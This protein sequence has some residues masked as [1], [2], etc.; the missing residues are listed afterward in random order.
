MTQLRP[1]SLCN[2]VYKIISKV[3]ANR[4]KVLLPK[5]ISPFKSAFVP[6]RAIS[7]NTILTSEIANFLC[8]RPMGKK[9]FFTLKL[10]MCKAYDKIKWSYLECVLLKLGFNT[11]WVNL[12][13][14]CVYSVLYTFIVN[15]SPRGYALPSRGLR[16]GDPISP[17][18]FL[19][20]AKG[21]SVMIAKYECSD[22]IQGISNH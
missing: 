13:M 3:L 10:D 17:Y 2:V 19:L 7:N 22:A 14:M 4:L 12:I 8:K 20:C 9:G 6:G 5:I 1:I 21:L 16:Q 18:I 15:G 11:K